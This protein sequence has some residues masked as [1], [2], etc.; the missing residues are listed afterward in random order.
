MAAGFSFA[1]DGTFTF[2]YA[3]GAVDRIAQGT[4]TVE[5][6]LLK[7]KS[8]KEPGKDFLVLDQKQQGEGYTIQVINKTPALA[9]NVLCVAISDK[10][11]FQDYT[12]N[13]GRAHLPIPHCEKLYVKHA[14]FPDVLTL[15]KDSDNPN[16]YFEL[17]LNNS[18]QKV[19][20]KG[21]DFHIQGDTITCASNYFMMLDDIVFVR[22]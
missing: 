10:G 1:V 5:G 13:A 4:F 9:S 18:L 22:K 7:L 6:D 20:F 12:D 17:K 2:Y 21:I 3:Y 8:D 14:L 15:I 16:N 19:S 11:R